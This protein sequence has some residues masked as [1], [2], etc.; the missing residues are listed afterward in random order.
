[1]GKKSLIITIVG[2][3]GYFKGKGSEGNS[4]P[5]E[6]L[7]FT[8]I[9]ETYLPLLSMFERLDIDSVPFKLSLVLTPTLCAQLADY[10]VQ[11]RFVEWLD[12]LVALGEKE[13]SQLPEG[14]PRWIQ[15]ESCLERI[16]AN[17][18]D[19]VEFY[20]GD[21]LSAFRY[22]ADRDTIELL[23]T[24]ATSTFLPHYADIPEAINAQIEAGLQS[25]R[26]FFG[27][28][29]DGFWLPAM[30]YSAN[31]EQILLKY[32]FT[33][34]VLDS[35]GL[36][37]GKPLPVN[38]I[39]SPIRCQNGFVFF[40]RDFSSE[41]EILGTDGFINNGVYRNQDRDLAFEAA[42]NELSDFIPLGKERVASGYKYWRRGGSTGEDWYD[43]DAAIKQAKIDALSFVATRAEKLNK[44]E[45]MLQS[46]DL[47]MTC[48]FDARIFGQLWHEGIFWL[49]QVFRAAAVS[50]DLQTAHACDLFSKK[51]SFQELV[52]FMSAATG[53]GYGENLLDT[54]N[55]WMLQYSRKA[56]ERMISLAERFPD[57]N[58]FKARALNM[59]AKEVLL[60]M[61]LDWPIMLHD[62][63]Y[64]EYA[65]AQFKNN[66][67]AFTTVFDSLGANSI[68]TEWLTNMEQ[69][70]P[71]FPWIN[72]RIFSKKK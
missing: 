62:K 56:C 71:L 8:A 38:G 52:P 3:Q 37:F 1:M 69:E 43:K 23:A 29:P 33:Y 13:V 14:S 21:L 63:T 58:G 6:E 4:V 19:F 15:A 46:S 64:P 70:H 59:A 60:S 22:Y 53:T 42:A 18:R 20:K 26:Q 41:A 2:H 16:R 66:V 25:H 30:G 31:I 57:D 12:R 44:A 36:L 35:H 28:V 49:E 17:R 34:S 39:F 47:S 55:D 65:E 54:S 24:A 50:P 11:T 27:V 40:A 32:G 10:D 61:S 5:E 67:L 7:L 45:T 9:S 48:T 68:S 72:Y 51:S